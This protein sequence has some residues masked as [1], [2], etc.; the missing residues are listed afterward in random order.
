[1][2]PCQVTN[3][4]Q[5]RKGIERS[6]TNLLLLFYNLLL[7]ASCLPTAIMVLKVLGTYYLVLCTW[8]L[9]LIPFYHIPTQHFRKANFFP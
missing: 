8:Y 6:S 5:N 7:L 3:K 2:N 4:A 9:V 1:M